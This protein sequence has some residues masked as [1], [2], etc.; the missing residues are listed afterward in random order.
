MSLIVLYFLHSTSVLSFYI[1]VVLT[2]SIIIIIIIIFIII[3]HYCYCYCYCDS[4]YKLHSVR[5]HNYTHIYAISQPLWSRHAVTIIPLPWCGAA[6][7]SLV[8]LISSWWRHG[9]ETLSAPLT[10][11]LRVHQSLSMVSVWHKIFSVL[12]TPF[13][14]FWVTRF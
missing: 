12:K 5:Q 2:L 11:V 9:M 13:N 10:L 4:C 1:D 3:N 7:Q 6:N 14:T 8:T